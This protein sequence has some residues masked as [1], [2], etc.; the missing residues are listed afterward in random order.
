MAKYYKIEILGELV[1]KLAIS[2]QALERLDI[3]ESSSVP[4]N[5][6]T[7]WF[8]GTLKEEL[9]KDFEISTQI[10]EVVL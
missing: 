10:E 9:I 7:D 1:A 8:I 2:E 6:N 3:K 4:Y 5:L